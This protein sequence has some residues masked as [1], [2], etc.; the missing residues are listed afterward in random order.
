[1]TDYKHKEGVKLQN[2]LTNSGFGIWSN[3]TL[4]NV[5]SDFVTNG[6]F[7]SD[8]TG[9]TAGNAA[10]LASVAGGESGNALRILCDGTENPYAYQTFSGLT[11]GKL[12]KLSLYIKQ[13]TEST[14][15]I[16]VGEGATQFQ[17]GTKTGESTASWVEHTIT[18]EA[19]VTNPTVTLIQI[20][21]ASAGTTLFFDTITCYE[22]TPGCVA[23]LLK[24]NKR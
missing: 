4:E 10:T 12:Y 20:A 21:S 11:I 9:W 2:L 5:G 14:Y 24:G 7:G 22:V 19:T 8:T 17:M 13:G 1:M 15:D 16:R 23:L 6:G 18:F 3:S